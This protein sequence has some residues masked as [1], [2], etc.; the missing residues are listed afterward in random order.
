MI[1][2]VTL[3]APWLLRIYL[4]Q[5]EACAAAGCRVCAR[6]AVR[7][8][9]ELLIRDGMGPGVRAHNQAGTTSRACSA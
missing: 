9:A 6:D 1:G 4:A 2:R 3:T 7:Y 5:A 8:R